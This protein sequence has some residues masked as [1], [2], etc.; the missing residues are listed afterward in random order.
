VKRLIALGG[1]IGLIVVGSTLLAHVRRDGEYRRLLAEG[2]LAMRNGQSYVAIEHFSGALALR[3]DS[4]AAFYRRGEAYAERQQDESAIRDLKAAWQLAPDAPQPLQALGHL[5]DRRGDAGQAAEWYALAADRLQDADPALLYA[6]ALARY[7]AGAPAAARDPLRRA[8]A[9]NDS[10]PEA[11]YLLGLVYRDSQNPE[12]AIASLERAVRLAPTLVAA[13]EELADLYRENNRPDDAR[14]QLATLA[15]L[16]S[17][18]NRQIALALA[19]VAVGRF[20]EALALLGPINEASS[21]NSRVAL[22]VARIHLAR[23]ERTGDH[24]SAARALALLEKALGGTARRSEGHALFGRA[25]YLTGDA[26]GAERLLQDAIATSPIDP[27]AFG[28]LADAA[29][30]LGHAGVAL[31]ALVDLDALEGDT[32]S[33]ERRAARA[34]RIGVLA[35]ESSDWRTAVEHLRAATQ[36]GYTDAPTLGLLARAEWRSGD[37]VSA[38]NSLARALAVDARN[39]DLRRL[40]RL[41]PPNAGPGGPAAPH[42]RR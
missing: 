13:R 14:A 23:A 32:A 5:Y 6:L 3:P 28:F 24:A 19:D 4:M 2:E 26:A 25:L 37:L 9:R 40:S 18:V 1:V 10:I 17:E 33:I 35:V 27:E 12:Q 29:E 16:D 11:H 22:A 38:R 41:I 20:D 39:T 15:S 30:R 31:D 21:G 7:R 36:A 34:R 8:L 42:P